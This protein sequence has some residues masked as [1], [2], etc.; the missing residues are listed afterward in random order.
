MYKLS[1]ESEYDVVA[2]L[3]EHDTMAHGIEHLKR[4]LELGQ[5]DDASQRVAERWLSTFRD[6][7]ASSGQSFGVVSRPVPLLSEDSGFAPM[8]SFG[9]DSMQPADN[10]D[11]VNAALM[12]IRKAAQS[13]A[14]SAERSAAA[15]VR[16]ARWGQAALMVSLLG[17]LLVLVAEGPTFIQLLRR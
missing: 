15:A 13:A 1:F 5:L 16:G 8:S 11:S 10:P 14:A 4:V 3:S 6:V 17:L 9:A 12:D 7:A 2:W